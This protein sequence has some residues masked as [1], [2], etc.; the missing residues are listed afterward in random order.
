VIALRVGS[1]AELLQLIATADTAGL[2]THVVQD[3]GRT[4]VTRRRTLEAPG[5]RLRRAQARPAPLSLPRILNPVGGSGCYAWGW[6]GGGVA[7]VASGTR[8]VAAIGPGPVAQI[9]TVTGRL[10][11]L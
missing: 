3:A 8:T 4:Q 7:Q 9:D 10:Q 5:L 2:V 1:E 6:G 11:L